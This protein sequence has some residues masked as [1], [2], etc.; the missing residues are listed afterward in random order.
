[1]FSQIACRERYWAYSL[2]LHQKRM[3]IQ[4]ALCNILENFGSWEEGRVHNNLSGM[5]LTLAGRNSF[6]TSTDRFVSPE[7][8]WDAWLHSPS[9]SLGFWRRFIKVP[10]SPFLFVKGQRSSCSTKTFWLNSERP[11][12]SMLVSCLYDF[13]TLSHKEFRLGVNMGGA[14]EQMCYSPL[15]YKVLQ[16]S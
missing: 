7:L 6:F 14:I 15:E 10:T 12:V 2:F 11:N 16:R 1:M 5:T 13:F 8:L 3:Y 4:W 9:L